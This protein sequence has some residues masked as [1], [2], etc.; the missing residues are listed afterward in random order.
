MCSVEN[1][2]DALKT[3]P[4]AVEAVRVLVAYSPKASV[5][6]RCLLQTT[7][8]ALAAGGVRPGC[9]DSDLKEHRSRDCVE[10]F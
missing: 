9:T 4:V 5:A 1:E 3:A 2:S 8:S 10:L 6:T 7:W